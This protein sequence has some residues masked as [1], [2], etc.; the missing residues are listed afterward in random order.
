MHTSVNTQGEDDQGTGPSPVI[1]SVRYQS[2]KIWVG[3]L[4][5]AATVVFSLIVMRIIAATLIG[6][7]SSP[8]QQAAQAHSET[9]EKEARRKSRSRED[10]NTR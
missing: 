3:V 4:R 6:V 1:P 8:M 9:I 7:G 5:Y 10:Y 2:M